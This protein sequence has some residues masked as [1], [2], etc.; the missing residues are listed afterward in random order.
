MI[1]GLANHWVGDVLVVEFKGQLALGNSLQQ[2]E[3]ELRKIVAEHQKKLIID[4]SELDY[5]DSAGIGV[6]VMTC[7]RLASSGGR[8]CLA[9]AHGKVEKLLQIT[10]LNRIATLCGSVPE[11]VATLGTET[12]GAVNG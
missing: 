6:L 9:G 1:L 8:V 7:G 4:V 2:A 10:H 12:E 3:S 11:A 5:L